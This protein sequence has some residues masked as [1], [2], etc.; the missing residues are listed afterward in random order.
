MDYLS[1]LSEKHIDFN[2]IM[3]NLIESTVER[4]EEWEEDAFEMMNIINH[5]ASKF[6]STMGNW[7]HE[8][9]ESIVDKVY[10]HKTN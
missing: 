9:I 3:T 7:A 1:S 4:I 10:N 2:D 8:F 5:I 6:S